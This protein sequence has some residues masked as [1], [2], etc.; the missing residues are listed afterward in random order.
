[1]DGKVRSIFDVVFEA[2]SK[3]IKKADPADLCATDAIRMVN[4]GKIIEHKI[5]EKELIVQRP[6][7][8]NR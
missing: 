3:I 7:D 5:D 4:M 1:M 8:T 6:F 2:F